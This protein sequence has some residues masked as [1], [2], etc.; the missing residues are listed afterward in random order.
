MAMKRAGSWSLLM[1]CCGFLNAQL[2]MLDKSVTVME[3]TEL[4][5]ERGGCFVIDQDGQWRIYRM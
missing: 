2:G 3:A 4:K 5:I 1:I